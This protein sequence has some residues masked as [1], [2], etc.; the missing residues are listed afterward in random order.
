MAP[1]SC[2][3]CRR[4]RIQCIE[5]TADGCKTCVRRSVSCSGPPKKED[6]QKHTRVAKGAKMAEVREAF[7]T[8]EA[9]LQVAT[10][11]SPTS[12]LLTFEL[13][14]ALHYHLVQSARLVGRQTTPGTRLDPLA[15]QL[16]PTNFRRHKIQMALSTYPPTS[17]TEGSS[18]ASTSAGPLGGSAIQRRAPIFSEHADTTELV[19]ACFSAFGARWSTHSV[20]L[21]SL[22]DRRNARS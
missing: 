13:Q 15:Y 17:S 10:V 6:H 20:R 14:A 3:E 12:R 5:L 7:G 8:N 19:H 1:R 11:N 18:V 9:P 22:L 4:R 16:A 2:V 21:S